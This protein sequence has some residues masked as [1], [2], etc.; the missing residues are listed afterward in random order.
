MGPAVVTFALMAFYIA[1]SAQ[2]CK[3]LVISCRQHQYMYLPPCSSRSRAATAGCMSLYRI[4]I[5]GCCFRYPCLHHLAVKPHTWHVH[6][7]IALYPG[8]QPICV[9]SLSSVR[10]ICSD[11]IGWLAGSGGICKADPLKLLG[12]QAWQQDTAV[13]M[14]EV[15]EEGSFGR[16]LQAACDTMSVHCG[17]AGPQLFSHGAEA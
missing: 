3:T 2:S 4:F 17:A 15:V 1:A 14:Y 12:T 5:A 10:L 13:Y 7:L 8:L 11:S 6:I 16:Q 9:R